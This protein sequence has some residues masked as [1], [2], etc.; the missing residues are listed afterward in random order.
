MKAPRWYVVHTEPRAGFLAADELSRDGFQVLFPQAKT[1]RPQTGLGDMPLAPGDQ[2]LR[3][4]A[5][6]EGCWV[7]GLGFSVPVGG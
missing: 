3:C 4:H 7:R 1:S 2:S 5:N 6:G